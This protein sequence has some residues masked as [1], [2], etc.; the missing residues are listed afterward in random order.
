ML[1]DQNPRQHFRACSRTFPISWAKQN[2]A[3]QV[4]LGLIG[5]FNSS[6]GIEADE[7][8]F[9]HYRNRIIS[10]ITDEAL[11]IEVWSRAIV[12]IETGGIARH[13]RCQEWTYLPSQ[14]LLHE[15]AA[16]E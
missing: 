10:P 4:E 3:K 1:L 7:K 2:L 12:T 16:A 15:H 13:D 14:H 6:R 11:T 9:G 5:H 8:R